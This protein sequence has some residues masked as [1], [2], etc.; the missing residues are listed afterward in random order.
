MTVGVTGTGSAAEFLNA[1]WRLV[2][3]GDLMLFLHVEEKGP[4]GAVDHG[5]RG[6]EHR[7]TEQANS[8]AERRAAGGVVGWA[9]N[10]NRGRMW[11]GVVLAA[12]PTWGEGEWV[13]PMRN[14]IILYLFKMFQIYLNEFYQKMALLNWKI[15][16]KI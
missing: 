2:T 14:S 4:V 7:A 12:G 15:L 8:D 16:N 3:G 5:A 1:R 9:K 10:K 11:A 13:G 6:A